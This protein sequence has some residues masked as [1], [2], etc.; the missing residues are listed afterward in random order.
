MLTGVVLERPLCSRTSKGFLES[1][2]FCLELPGRGPRNVERMDTLR[3]PAYLIASCFAA[4]TLIG[5]GSSGTNP[6]GGG[7]GT[8]T[9]DLGTLTPVG[10]ANQY[11]LK[12]IQSG[13]F[14]GIS[15]Q[16]QNAG[17]SVVAETANGTTDSFWHFMPMGNQ[18]FN[19]ENMLTH[20]VMGVSNASTAAGATVLQ[21][22]DNGTK[23][24]LWAFYLLSDGNYLV[25]NVN[26][27]LYL[28]SGTAIDQGTRGGSGSGCTCQE[29]AVTNTGNAA[30]PAP[31]AVSG[32]GIYVHD[33]FMLQDP[34]T[35][36]YWLYGTHQTLAYSTDGKTFTY[37]SANSAEGACTAV[38][39]TAWL[40]SD[41][42]CPIIGPDF[43]SW[44][45]LQTP[46]AENNGADTDVWAPSLL[47]AT[48]V[49]YQYYA[50]PYEPSTG[51]EAVIGL[52]ASTTPNGPW[53]DKGY[54]VTSWTAA[55][56]QPPAGN[57]WGFSSSTTWNAIDPAP[58]VDAN[59][60]WWLVF[61][62][63][64]DGAHL[65]QLD[66]AT[67]LRIDSKMYG[68]AS[69][70]AGEEGPFIYYWNGYY[71]YFAPI[72]VCCNGVSSTYRTI[73]G[74]SSSVAGPYYDRGGLDLA[75]GGGTILV[76]SNGNIFGPGGGSVFTDTGTDGSQS[77]PTF[78]YHYYDGDNNGTPTLGINRL[79]FDSDGW[80]SIE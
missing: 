37:T 58:F 38:E 7:G 73:V 27:G 22:A 31:M 74:R 63:W 10:D 43:S 12:N 9:P 78:V 25:Q 70:S 69:R 71:Y 46:L 20:Q 80:P 53:T 18:Q 35:H 26:S 55:T 49:Y 42:R 64:Q 47:Y 50:I 1:R 56:T 67:G 77:L 45:G 13:L 30:Y 44:A 6:G 23:D 15:G 40:T 62:S 17:A 14:L 28:E 75:S 21:W 8:T 34:G 52:A 5:C 57:P 41:N 79:V 16:S 32:T 48:G 33:P 72:N 60:N 66:P 19:I 11:M 54:V 39:G 29:W 3:F 4:S 59:G 68:I 61:G 76:S 65:V 36:I 2:P 51:A 24:H